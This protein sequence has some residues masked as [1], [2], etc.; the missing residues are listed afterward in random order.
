MDAELKERAEKVAALS[1]SSTRFTSEQLAEIGA[2]HYEITG[3]KVSCISCNVYGLI[4]RIQKHLLPENLKTEIMAYKGQ[5][6][7]KAPSTQIIRHTKT[8]TILITPDNLHEKDNFEYA[9]KNFPHLVEEAPK[10]KEA[11]E[12][13]SESE[14]G[15]VKSR[16]KK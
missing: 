7:P 8:G 1:N 13:E 10:K 14:E 11:E 5:F 15:E 2:V 16:A 6:K 9:L 3:H 12:S 4:S